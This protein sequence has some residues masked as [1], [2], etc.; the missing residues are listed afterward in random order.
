MAFDFG[1]YVPNS[2]KYP[3]GPDATFKR[4]NVNQVRYK[5]LL[6]EY[7]EGK[8]NKLRIERF[9]QKWMEK[10]EDRE[11]RWEMQF[12]H[13]ELKDNLLKDFSHFKQNGKEFIKKCL[14][15]GSKGMGMFSKWWMF[16][17]KKSC[18]SGELKQSPITGKWHQDY[19]P[20]KSRKIR[21]WLKAA[22][23]GEVFTNSLNKNRVKLNRLPTEEEY[24]I[25]DEATLKRHTQKWRWFLK[26]T[27]Y[28]GVSDPEK[29]RKMWEKPDSRVDY[30]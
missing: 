10:E 12:K 14:D 30:K 13:N 1:K 22:E 21:D 6:K 15:L 4:V 24:G 5:E 23:N 9:E 3:K 20:N 11:R 29:R 18:G 8:V 27:N 17:P 26:E 25:S 16:K 19:K 28:M 7:E 2:F